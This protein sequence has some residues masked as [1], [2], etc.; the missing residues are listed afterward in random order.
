VAD[1]I[2]FRPPETYSDAMG[3]RRCPL[4]LLALGGALLER[5]LTVAIIDPQAT[6]DWRS[7]LA[8]ALDESTICAGVTVMTGYP[9]AGALEFARAAKRIRPIPVVF[10]G[11]H[12][13]L[14]GEQTV[15]HELVDVAF[16]GEGEKRFPRLVEA[17]RDDQRLDVIPGVL[18]AQGGE[19]RGT[20]DGGEFLDL[21]ALAF[22]AYDLI[23]VEYYAAHKRRFMHRRKR[24]LDLNTDR[25]CP[26][27]C[28]FCYN[29]HV[30]RRR[31]RA[32]SAEGVLDAVERLV[33]TYRLD[34][35]NFVAD[36]FFVSADRVRRICRGIID[37]KLDIA[38]HADI[39]I[40]TFAR[41]DDDLVELMH[42]SGCTTLTFGVESG[43]Q[44]ILDLINKD[45]SVEEVRCAH[46]R[47][48]G[49]GF[50]LNYH[51]M[52]GLPG[53]NR[54]DVRQ[55]LKLI[56]FLLRC[57]NTVIF[58][59]TMYLPYPGTALYDR[60]LQQGMD[61]PGRLEDWAEWDWDAPSRLRWLSRRWR[62]YLADVRTVARGAGTRRETE[63]PAWWLR[64]A[65]FR[66]RFAAL[67]RGICLYD[68]DH[69]F[70]RWLKRLPASLR[71][72]SG[73]S[74]S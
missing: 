29:V 26:H 61:P 69:R 74:P 48:V 47:A 46:E 7:A 20:P 63:S 28:G 35:V 17:L 49:L 52:I 21:D 42:R 54:N 31:W 43:S 24:C 6:P 62:G 38:W 70:F 67:M 11:M 4:G 66:L 39:R 2:L 16:V 72:R 18:F 60:C 23:D 9:I 73:S 10:G 13:T 45:I 58:G 22:P 64:S 8:G 65:Y 3:V 33:R 41:M 53:E 34:A 25:G 32:L 37:R 12:P 55:S 15:R 44:R 59:P 57:R 5:G 36:N 71:R 56:R 30:N 14:L 27:R 68:L 1:V 50:L 19:V 51:F 40:D